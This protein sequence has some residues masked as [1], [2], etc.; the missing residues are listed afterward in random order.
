MPEPSWW[1]TVVAWSNDHSRFVEVELVVRG[2]DLV[3][4]VVLVVFLLMR[5]S[6]VMG[7]PDAFRGVIRVGGGEID[8]SAIWAR[9]YG[10]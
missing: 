6:W 9:W 4:L 7:Q 2:G 8:G 1:A 10:R 3:V 5:K